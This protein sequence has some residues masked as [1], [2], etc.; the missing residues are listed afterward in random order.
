MLTS[1]VTEA[2][3]RWAILKY[4]CSTIHKKVVSITCNNKLHAQLQFT[5]WSTY[6]MANVL[7]KLANSTILSSCIYH[8]LHTSTYLLYTMWHMRPHSSSYLMLS[9]FLILAICRMH[10]TYELSV[11]SSLVVSTCDEFVKGCGFQLLEG[12][13]IFVSTSRL[14]KLKL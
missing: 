6:N 10:V 8:H 9:T 3:R 14:L 2:S 5:Y 7:V 11:F 1:L 4:T 13:R 12:H